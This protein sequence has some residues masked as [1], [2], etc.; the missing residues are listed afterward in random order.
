MKVHMIP[1][2]TEMKKAIHLRLQGYSLNEIARQLNVSKASASVWVRGTVLS[3]RAQERIEMKRR[4]A[5]VKAAK[6]NHGR[7]EVNLKDVAM[8]AD[9]AVSGLRLDTQLIQ[10]MCALLYWCEGEKTKNDK[11]LTFANSDPRLV[12]TFLHLLRKGFE[13][14]EQK[15]RICLH[16]H[17]YHKEKVQ[18]KFWS[19]VTGIPTTQFLK[20]YHKQH[21]GTRKREGYAGC[22]SIRYYDTRVARQIQ[23]LA[24]AVLQKYGSIV[25]W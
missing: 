13:L 6:T 23:A 25:Q 8:V 21:T 7:T 16:L 15:F 17:D 9:L 22:A 18:K 12:A 20:T 3:K 2:R 5:R 11:T 10:V 1:K 4:E 19:E 24:R 14:D